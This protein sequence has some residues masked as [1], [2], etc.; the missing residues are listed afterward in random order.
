[1]VSIQ[2]ASASAIVPDQLIHYVKAVSGLRAERVENCLL[3]GDGQNFVLVAFPPENPAG[4]GAADEALAQI[5][6][7]RGVKNLTV[8]AAARPEAAPGNAVCHE[9][10]W[11]FLNLPAT[12]G[13]KTRNMLKRAARE[14]S[15]ARED[16]S[17]EI[18]ALARNLDERKKLDAG[19]RY[20]HSR[21]ADYINS[22]DDAILYAARTAA[23]EVAACA[24]ADY[25]SFST[26]FYMFAFRSPK[27]P[28][29][30]ADLVL[31][32]IAEEAADRGCYRLNLGLGIDEG[33]GF[34]KKKWGAKPELPH[35]ETSWSPQK[36]GF[37][38]RLFG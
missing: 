18:A 5:L 30:S 35:V 33:V 12:P 26:A 2:A 20:I 17:D 36:K 31:A 11:W 23:G 1:M 38:S 21:L 25:S 16:W 4:A 13:Q 15:V 37:F 3:H 6:K 14:V 7:R 24:I 8:L 29:G 34:F 19:S 32:K 10:A 28:P 22:S 27:A 9:D